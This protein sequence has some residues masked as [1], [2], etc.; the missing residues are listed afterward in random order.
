MKNL[1][2]LLLRRILTS[3]AVLGMVLFLPAWSLDSW[4][5]P[6]LPRG[7]AARPSTADR[8]VYLPVITRG[9]PNGEL[10]R[11]QVVAP[12]STWRYLDD[13]SDPG[14]AWRQ[15]AFD[16]SH[17]RAGPGPLGYGDPDIVT[18]IGYG[19][20]RSNKY[21]TAYFRHS[22]TSSPG[23]YRVLDLELR[24][25]DGAVVY[26]NGVEIYRFNL[27]EGEINASTLA[28]RSLGQAEEG[29]YHHLALDPGSLAAGTNVLAVEVHQAA[30]DSSDLGFDLVLR[31]AA[32]SSVRFAVIGDYGS[33]N[34]DEARVASMVR[35]WAPDLVITTGDNN[36][37]LGEAE[38][39]DA[40]IGQF[41]HNFISPYT[42]AYGPGAQI[43]RFFP[44]LGNHDWFTRS[45][46]P[47]LPRPY[48][49]YFTLPGNERYYDFTWG[50][51]HF[52]ALSSDV[53]EPDGRTF[54]SIQADWFKPRIAAADLPWKIVYF[55]HPPYTAGANLPTPEMDWPFASYGTDL[56]LMGHDHNYQRIQRH[57]ISYI[58]NGAGGGDL[59]GVP[60]NIDGLAAKYFDSHGA[61]LVQADRCWLVSRFINDSSEVID[62]IRLSS[63]EAGCD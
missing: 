23:D 10:P 14:S 20:D 12:G 49:D 7:Q 53:N 57:G 11:L 50:P 36:Y 37:D 5:N 44:S 51:V 38:T 19:P 30:P 1:A 42:G 63:G 60:G 18:L 35:A 8:P 2:H 33:G 22:F 54:T 15:P 6:G 61:M 9:Q 59:Y 27:P 34:Q 24:C 17:W 26:L 31:G 25:D 58:I 43:N 55:H 16:D 41:Y 32:Y 56:V 39:I 3:A 47:A 62:T 46:T 21:I 28:L 40:N 52:F 45:G 29:R 48:L 13:G 4:Q